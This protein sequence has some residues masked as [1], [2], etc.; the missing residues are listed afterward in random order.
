MGPI[1]VRPY[2]ESTLTLRR[3]Y[4]FSKCERFGTDA[5]ILAD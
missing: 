4:L 2:G 1:S 3:L 5:P